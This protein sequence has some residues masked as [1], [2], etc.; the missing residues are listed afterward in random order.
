[1]MVNNMNSKF[2]IDEY[3]KKEKNKV[4]EQYRLKYHLVPP[5][6]WMNDPNGLIFY[7]GRY[8]LFY[9]YNP[10]RSLPGTMLWGHATSNDLVSFKDE[11]VALVPTEDFTSIFSGGAIEE[12]NTLTAVYTLH[13]EQMDSKREEVYLSKSLDGVSFN[14]PIKIF[15]NETLPKHISREDFRDPF[16]IMINDRYYVFVGGKDKTLNQGVIIVL[17]GLDLSHLTYS[18]SIGP[19][20]ELGDMAECP[21]YFRMNDKDVL[22]VS[23]CHVQTR[24][25]DFKNI[26][27]S[28]F[29]VGN[30][31]FKNGNMKVDFIKEIDKGDAFYA[32][33]FIN[34]CK[35]PIMIGWMEMWGKEYPTH[36]L[37]H[38]WTGAFTIPRRVHIQNNDIFQTPVASLDSHLKE[39]KNG[40]YPH[41]LN[42]TFEIKNQ[43]C[44]ILSSRNGKVI[45]GLNEQFYL[46]TTQSNNKNGFIRKTNRTYISCQV[47]VLL[48]V[49]SIEIFVD[50]GR[51]AISSRIYL[52]GDY[53]LSYNEY[54]SDV[55]IQEVV[56]SNEN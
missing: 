51:E 6:G 26:N 22:L 27:S 12:Q 32:P 15:D 33:Q 18:F 40:P 56:M 2:E 14:K 41:C 36:E 28:I 37:N 23:G 5:I 49:S 52:D 44:F 42:I 10:Y 4:N 24:D 53:E 8:H 39:W 1:M 34:G 48:D 9:Q 43:G 47:R 50:N 38:H 21:S 19:F 31:D 7:Q 55:C 25:N 29:V 17:S 16:P 13:Y 20:Y 54:V 30:I 3:I 45:F 46:D 35:D 11:E